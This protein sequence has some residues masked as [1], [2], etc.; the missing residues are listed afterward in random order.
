MRNVRTFV[1]GCAVLG[2]TFGLGAY[3]SAHGGDPNRVHACVA[4]NGSL[5][6]VAPPTACKPTETALDWDIMGPQGPIGLT[7]PKGSTGTTGPQGPA[8]PQGSV[9]PQ[10]P[11]GPAG[12]TGSQGQ[13]GPQGEPGAQGAA[14][15]SGYEIVSTALPLDTSAAAPD[16]DGINQ[17]WHHG[18]SS[19]PA[20]KSVISASHT[21]RRY[22][23][24]R[25]S[26]NE[27]ANL[28]QWGTRLSETNG[29]GG[30]TVYVI[31]PTEMLLT[32]DVTMV[33][34]NVTH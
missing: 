23:G 6:V 33:C 1:I 27:W 19:C 3:V 22:D 2:G 26:L 4:T 16:S 8:G 17:V 20:G 31:N 10:G 32:A 11:E 30:Y 34:A 25:L 21:L 9:G 12:Q 18:T 13:A 7:G 5:R 29:T 15:L 24:L 14:G 28:V